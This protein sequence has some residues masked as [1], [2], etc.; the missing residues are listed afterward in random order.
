MIVEEFAGDLFGT[1]TARLE[2][3]SVYIGDSLGRYRRRPAWGP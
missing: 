2:V 1:A 3:A